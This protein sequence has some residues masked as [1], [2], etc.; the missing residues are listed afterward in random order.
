MKEGIGMRRWQRYLIE[1]LIFVVVVMI[2]VP[3]VNHFYG[4]RP[5]TLIT[6]LSRRNEK[7][8]LSYVA[9]GDS[10]TQGVGDTTNSGGFV[11]IVANLVRSDFS[12]AVEA[13]NF[14]VNG[15]TSTQI[16]NRMN[17]EEEIQEAIKQAD[18]LTITVGGNDMLKVMRKHLVGLTVEDFE[19]PLVQYRS[20][21]QQLVHQIREWNKEAPIYFLGVYN[22]FFLNFPELTQMQ[23][24]IDSYNDAT[25][26]TVEQMEKCYF[27]PINDLL[28][29]GLEGEEG[30]M[31]TISGNQIIVNDALYEGDRFHP[32]NIGYQLMAR[33][34]F[35]E[36][37]QTQEEW[38]KK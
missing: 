7:R 17:R 25:K 1:C 3:V 22:P 27:I 4:A 20:R 18:F 13:Q 29:R 23:E 19:Q 34:V 2:A 30:I 33:A 12:V 15:N 32:N 35:E 38:L 8:T 37:K 5:S 26:R 10:L 11:P 24:I 31:E 9:I 21:I 14:G 28:Y 16:I 36:M 6:H